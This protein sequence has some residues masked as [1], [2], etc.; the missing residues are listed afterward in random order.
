M[1]FIRKIKKKSGTYMAEVESYRVNGKVKQRVVK[2]LGK[3]IDGQIVRK[4]SSK[5]ISLEYVKKS[6]DVLVIDKLAE[7]LG[8]KTIEN[9]NILVLVYAQ[10]L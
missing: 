5:D 7:E 3:N 1:V 2:Y 9:K 10:L 8:F 4:T 6:L